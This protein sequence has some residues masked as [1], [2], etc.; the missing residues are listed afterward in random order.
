M[1]EK[2]PSSLIIQNCLRCSG[3]ELMRLTESRSDIAFFECPSCQRQYAQKP[4]RPLVYRWLHA[5]SL[6][7][8]VV[9][10]ESEP[11]SKAQ[12]VAENLAKTHARDEMAEMI[13]EID[14]EL[15]HPTQNIRDILDNRASE[16]KCREFLEAFVAHVRSTL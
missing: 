10:F 6:P 7:L 4:G 8:Y 11:L 2:N 9:L 3:V 14:L 15:R 5:I 12:S 13:D 16:E 1:A